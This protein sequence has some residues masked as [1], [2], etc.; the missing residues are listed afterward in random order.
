[1]SSAAERLA[2]IQD[3]YNNALSNEPH[4]LAKAQ[5]AADVTAIQA[6][7]ANARSAYYSAIAAQLTAGGADVENAFHAARAARD[8]VDEARA[9]SAALATLLQTLTGA[10]HAATSLLELAKESK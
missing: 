8:A 4:D 9:E 1:M 10:T 7:L 3:N 6:N 2:V 5:T